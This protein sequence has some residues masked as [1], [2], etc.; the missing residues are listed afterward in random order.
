MQ[1]TWVQTLGWEDPL[2]KEMATQSS[3]LAGKFQGQRKR[4]LVGYSPRGHRVRHNE[5][6]RL[7]LFFRVFLQ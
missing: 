4:S 1:E 6:L 3:I 7:S 2:E 5:Q